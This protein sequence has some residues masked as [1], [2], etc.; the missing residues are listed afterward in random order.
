M[1]LSTRQKI[2][3]VTFFIFVVAGPL[4]CLIKFEL[5]L[6]YYSLPDKLMQEMA[7][8]IRWSDVW[9]IFL[10]AFLLVYTPDFF[11]QWLR[12]TFPKRTRNVT[13]YFLQLTFIGLFVFSVIYSFKQWGEAS[14]GVELPLELFFDFFLI[15]TITAIFSTSLIEMNY[16]SIQWEKEAV[17]RELLQ[18][19]HLQAQ[20]EVLKSQVNPHFLF[21]SFNTLSELIS[22]KPKL[23][24][25]FVQ[26]LSKIFRFV[27]ENRSNEIVE[28]NSELKLFKSY[29]FLMQI[30]FGDNLHINWNVPDEKK[31]FGIVP[32]T[33]QILLEN[34]VKHNIISKDKPLHIT[35]E[36][37]NGNR[38]IFRNNL[39]KKLD[40]KT[41]TT[42]IGL[43]NIMNRYKYVADE[44]IDIIETAKEFIVKVPLIKIEQI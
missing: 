30:R 7:V 21:N 39:Q 38:L 13:R 41:V 27:L 17:Q 43:Q 12:R 19:E 5:M 44:A 23:A 6:K 34:A 14:L 35:V 24:I 2:N 10:L 40:E 25:D 1:K 28:L 20:F 37:D 31:Q 36:L 33:L 29:L 22:S 3:L 9:Q 4:Y 11:A 16:L 8:P 26:E 32:L 15:C 18:K 42:K